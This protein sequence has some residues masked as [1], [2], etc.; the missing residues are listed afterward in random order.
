[1]PDA[2]QLDA[3]Q[4]AVA[5]ADAEQR[6][7]VTAA[8]GQ[9]KTEVVLGRLDHLAAEG[10]SIRDEV[11][12]LSFSRAAVDAVRR[13]ASGNG[14]D[15]VEIRTFD[16][17]AASVLADAG[18]LEEQH[19]FDRRIRRATELI[20]D[21]GADLDH[22]QHLIL[23]ESQD[24]VGDRAEMV[25]ALIGELPDAGFTVLGDPLQGVYD[26]QLDSETSTSRRTSAEF[27][28]ALVEEHGAERTTL[29]GHYRATSDRMRGIVPV[30]D[31]LRSLGESGDT[32]ESGFRIL[33]EY[34]RRGG[35]DPPYSVRSLDPLQGYLTDLGR[36]ETTAVLAS[37]N[38]EV[39]RLSEL[40][41]EQGVEHVVRRRA[42]D[43]GPA[44]WVALVLRN[45]ER[46]KYQR[47]EFEVARAR[48]PEAPEDAW[49]LLREAAPDRRDFRTLDVVALNRRLRN[50][51]TPVALA[52]ADGARVVLS[53]VHRA[54]GLEF[55]HVID[56]EADPGSRSAERSWRSLRQRYVAS[57][58]ARESLWILTEPPYPP[59]P[60][61]RSAD[62]WLECRFTGRGSR[63]RPTRI[64][65]TNEDVESTLPSEELVPGQRLLA[66][67]AL[68]G[69]TVEI[70]LLFDPEPGRE[71]EYW[72]TH[73]GAVLARV[74]PQFRR[75]LRKHLVF[76]TK[77]VEQQ[78]P[79][80]LHGA[81]VASVETA[82]CDPENTLLSGL[83]ETGFWLV[84]RLTGLIRPDWTDKTGATA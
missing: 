27:L 57:S 44:R 74:A 5:E 70:R 25:L 42:R 50:V 28:D 1:M 8:A 31:E 68:A 41:A 16:S 33:D 56:L 54:K 72:I 65:F 2:I 49:H 66:E 3:S 67:G 34:R 63:P 48:V 84:P 38:Y 81:S 52:P 55:D 21:E 59:A 62:R 82:V 17:F 14:L 39:L 24:L 22:I 12:V 29:T 35:D 32:V 23:D 36:D 53:T 78:W 73:D 58:R 46:R 30:G 77:G 60:R 80:V 69:R 6:L 71:P 19:G 40:L 47:D 11:L 51:T 64:E 7:I 20:L 26:F 76:S 75:A 15:G 83:G 45:L 4:R 10:V 61:Q 9:G 43:A 37:T 79:R 13:R 18:E